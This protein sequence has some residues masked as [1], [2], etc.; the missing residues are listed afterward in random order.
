M[1][2]LAIIHSNG[3]PPA[4]GRLV[5]LTRRISDAESQLE[6]LTRGRDQLRAE[7]ARADIA[8][9][10][11]DTLISED[12]SS[13]AAKLRSGASWALAHFGTARAQ[14]L[15]ASLSESQV[16]LGVGTKAL[17]SIE[18]EI[19]VAQREVSDLRAG[20]ED[21]VRAVLLEA[22]AGFREEVDAAITDLRESLTIVAALERVVARSDGSY[23]PNERIAIE[24]PAIGGRP[25]EAVVVPEASIVAGANVW[26]KYA[27]TLGENPLSSIDE[28]LFP[29]VNPHADDGTILYDRMTTTERKAVDQNRSQGVK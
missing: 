18:S 3:L 25:A 6:R 4:R 21:A 28:V 11:L 27:E 15:V 1:N 14:N 20:K 17:A 10:E 29:R 22:S 12:A 23:S 26:G 13:L 19:E 8:K 9:V 24:I 7:L 5:N 16:Q 2:A